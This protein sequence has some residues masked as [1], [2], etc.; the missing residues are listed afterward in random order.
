MVEIRKYRYE[1]I[2][3]LF[4]TFVLLLVTALGCSSGQSS[5][6]DKNDNK[7]QESK[8]KAP[9]SKEEFVKMVSN[10]DKYKG[11]KVNFYTKIFVEPEKDDD[12]IYIPAFAEPK[13]NEQNVIVVAD[14]KTDVKNEDIIHV[15]GTVRKSF[16]GENAL[17][18]KVTAPIIDAEK[19]E[20]TDYVT[21]FSR[22]IKTIEVN[23]EINQHGY[24]VKLNKVEIAENETRA[25]VTISNQ[26]MQKLTS[27][28]IMQSF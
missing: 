25:Y 8:A 16:E 24:I 9:L 18:G 15:I 19:V 10:P 1:K 21:T 27:G 20:K 6:S 2:L 26:S 11:S 13:N 14:P 7:K 23:K 3:S 5:N 28:I 17:G 4:F 22:P 12:G